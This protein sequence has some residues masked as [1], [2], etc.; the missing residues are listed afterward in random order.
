MILIRSVSSKRV[1]KHPD[2]ANPFKVPRSLAH[3]RPNAAANIQNES[4]PSNLAGKKILIRSVSSKR[5]GKHPDRGVDPFQLPR[6]LAQLAKPVPRNPEGLLLPD[7]GGQ[8]QRFFWIDKEESGS[9]RF[10][11][12]KSKKIV[13]VFHP[14]LEAIIYYLNKGI[15]NM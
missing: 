5:V 2:P 9:P 10:F 4:H 3:P 1:G 12:G 8:L 15:S 7:W 14:N 11:F 13:G 6:S